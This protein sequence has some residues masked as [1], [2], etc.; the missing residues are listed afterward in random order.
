MQSIR[1]VTTQVSWLRARDL[2][3]PDSVTRGGPV[4]GVT[5][6]VVDVLFLIVMSLVGAAGAVYALAHLSVPGFLIMGLFTAVPGYA[7]WVRFQQ[8]SAPAVRA[9]R[10]QGSVAATLSPATRVGD[11]V[12]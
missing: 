5:G 2:A 1:P 7:G 12:N 6:P 9:K 4:T 11:W 3:P 10:S 8:A